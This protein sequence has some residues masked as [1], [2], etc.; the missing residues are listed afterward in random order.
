MTR[1]LIETKVQISTLRSLGKSWGDIEK[2]TGVRRSTAQAIV[3]KREKTANKMSSG[4][5]KKLSVRDVRCLKR[6]VSKNRRLSLKEVTNTLNSSTKSIVSL[7]TVRR[8]LKKNGWRRRCAAVVPSISRT[9]RIQH[10]WRNILKDTIKNL[11]AF[12]TD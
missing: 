10:E 5:P 6:I 11:S 7:Q 12:Q 9:N 4:R 2:I 8:I 3:A 1:H